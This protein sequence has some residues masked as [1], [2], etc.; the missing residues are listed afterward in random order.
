[1]SGQLLTLSRRLFGWLP[2][3]VQT[4]PGEWVRAATGAAL[5][6]MCT[7]WISSLLYGSTTAMILL[8]PAGASAVLLF[9]VSTGALAQPWPVLGSYLLAASIGVAALHLPLPELAFAERMFGAVGL[10]VL[11]M[12]VLR[13]I[14]PPGS[15]MTV[16]ILLAGDLLEPLGG[17]LVLP[18]MLNACCLLFCATLYNNLTGVRYPKQ[19]PRTDLHRTRDVLPEQ[20]V[21]FTEEDLDRALDKLG[22]FVDITRHDLEQIIR[23]T[24]SSALRRKMGNIRAEQIMS[25]DI[26][27]VGPD[28]TV[29]QAIG[30]FR[31]HQVKTLPVV[32]SEGKVQGIISLSDLLAQLD[33]PMGRILPTRINLWRDQPLH[34][35]M[36]A[37]VVTVD[38]HTHIVDM[39]PLLS[40]QGLHCLP[41][42]ENGRIVGMV[43]Q[44]D[45][46]AALHRDLVNHL[47]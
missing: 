14:H 25:R 6:V 36:T 11:G 46:I 18:I 21:G 9:V 16:V 34:H 39:I 37:P 10:V 29:R 24:E 38:R 43:T 47:A 22:S 5:A 31:H 20:R 44:T 12:L 4:R 28:T 41:V 32:N 17:W 30:M 45:V 42:L 2:R 15:A 1:M 40:S 35:I 13:C 23:D 33:L 8:G 27:T 7:Y 19:A 3:T 26:R